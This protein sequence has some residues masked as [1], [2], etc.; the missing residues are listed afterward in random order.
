MKLEINSKRKYKLYK[1]IE[2]KHCITLHS[3]K[4][5]IIGK[6][7]KEIR[8]FLELNDNASTTYQNFKDTMKTGLRQIYTGECPHLRK[9]Q[10]QIDY[11]TVHL[12]VLENKNKSNLKL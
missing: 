10:V 2:T 8:Q 5:W 1:G 9:E 6:N 7:K 11:L 4:R 12:T 3:N